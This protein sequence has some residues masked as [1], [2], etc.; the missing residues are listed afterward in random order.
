MFRAIC[1]GVLVCASAWAQLPKAGAG[2]VVAGGGGEG[3]GSGLSSLTGNAPIRVSGTLTDPVLDWVML[4][5]TSINA[6]YTYVQ[7]DNGSIK[8]MNSGADRIVTLPLLTGPWSSILV[9]DNFGMITVNITGA[10]FNGKTTFTLGQ[11]DSAWFHLSAGG[12]IYRGF[13]VAGRI[14]SGTGV[15][16]ATRCDAAIDAGKVYMRTDAAAPNAS[17]YVCA[18]TV[19]TTYAWELVAGGGGGGGA[20]DLA[21]LND[22][23]ATATS[24]TVLTIA[25]GQLATGNHA[26][27]AS[28]G[29]SITFSGGSGNALVYL[30]DTGQL[31]TSATTG[32]TQSGLT[33]QMTFVNVATPTFPDTSVPICTLNVTSGTYTITLCGQANRVRN[34]VVLAGTGLIKT[35]ANGRQTLAVDPAVV[36][37]TSGN[38]GTGGGVTSGAGPPTAAS[39]DEAAETGAPYIDTNTGGDD[40]RCTR[41][42]S[43]G[44]MWLPRGI[45][46]SEGTLR[47]RDD[48]MGGAGPGT[49]GNLSDLNMQAVSSTAGTLAFVAGEANHY[50]MRRHT[51]ATTLDANA[52]FGFTAGT[53]VTGNISTTTVPWAFRAIFRTDPTAITN[54]YYCLGWCGSGGVYSAT[55][56]VG[57]I[58]D[59]ASGHSTWHFRAMNASVSTG[60]DT[61]T[62]V[63]IAAA[64][65][66]DFAM[67]STTAG[68]ICYSLNGGAATCH[69][70]N[71]PATASALAVMAGT[72]S[73]GTGYAIDADMI[74]YVQYLGGR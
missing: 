21:G 11:Q 51:S 10:E 5:S 34:S 59:S 61:D 12:V 30:D 35:T 3:G 13:I 24:S 23:K 62:T 53:N 20:T 25:P 36:C 70:A 16:A 44:W 2:V 14:Q 17:L 9:N 48:F 69:S 37:M 4:S 26:Y 63:S 57:L 60:T 32:V 72:R 29:G 55:H 56:H 40:W 19:G 28:I 66:Y 7:A 52:G 8:R 1:A 49:S 46:G 43:N 71:I 50:G 15:P 67:W 31:V 22:F 73:G 54:A 47:I 58:R 68:T 6:D 33:G 27:L 45:S 38:C 65:W 74:E 18:N 39:C 42:A 41:L 64:T